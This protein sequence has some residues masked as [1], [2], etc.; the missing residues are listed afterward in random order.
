MLLSVS[1]RCFLNET[2]A[3]GTAVGCEESRRAG[4]EKV[5]QK[6]RVVRENPS[7]SWRDFGVSAHARVL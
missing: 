2:N 5:A 6:H 7:G 4:G 3:G 1:P